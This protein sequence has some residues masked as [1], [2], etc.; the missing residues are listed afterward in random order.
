MVFRKAKQSQ[1]ALKGMSY[2]VSLHNW[3]GQLWKDRDHLKNSAAFRRFWMYFS[4]N[5]NLHD[6][7]KWVAFILMIEVEYIEPLQKF[8]SSGR[9]ELKAEWSSSVL[10][11]FYSKCSK[12]KLLIMSQRPCDHR[13]LAFYDALT[14]ETCLLYKYAPVR[15]DLWLLKH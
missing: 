6:G 15:R 7:W 8:V 14:R 4:S 5:G 10:G 1:N 13:N 9:V 2:F 12:Q 3:L 11:M